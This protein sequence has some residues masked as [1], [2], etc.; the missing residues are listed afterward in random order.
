M[1][2][3][4]LK[5]NQEN[6]MKFVLLAM[7]MLWATV[8]FAGAGYPAYCEG[9]DLYSNEGSVIYVFRYST[10]CEDALKD[11]RANRGRFCDVS[12]LV[13]EDGVGV[14]DFSLSQNCRDALK[15]LTYNWTGL[16][17]GDNNKIYQ[18][19]TAKEIADMTY[20]MECKNALNDANIY[21]GLFCDQGQMYTHLGVKLKDYSF[22]SACKSALLQVSRGSF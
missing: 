22:E 6:H 1:K 2:A 20:D 14:Y 13:R 3:L 4:R 8:S 9:A 17:C 12:S 16:F 18:V 21:R 19:S 7:S 15:R 5:T 10:E 11:A